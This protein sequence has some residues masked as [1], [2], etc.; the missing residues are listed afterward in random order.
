MKSY[1]K[2]VFSILLGVCVFPF[3]AYAQTVTND[4]IGLGMKPELAEYIAGILPG[5]S[6]LDN[7][8]YLKG[9]NQA[10]SADIDILK[11]DATDDTVLNADTGDTIKFAVAGTTEAT[12]AA[13]MLTLASGTELTLGGDIIS[14][15][16][17]IGA[18]VATGA[19]TA[20]NTTCA[21]ANG[22]C[23]FGWDT[24]GTQ[25]TNLACDGATAD[26]CLC[27]AAS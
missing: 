7:N 24:S 13:N 9:R 19:N 18:V 14:T 3:S 6:V 20:C 23:V 8:T 21:V 12:L 17:N 15:T 22:A 10:D 16:T 26:E 27:L 1:K 5:G 2:L 4:L 25:S 11:V